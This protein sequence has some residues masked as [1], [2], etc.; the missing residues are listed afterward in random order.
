MGKLTH[1][2]ATGCTYF[3]TTDAWQKRATFQVVEIAEIVVQRIL[4]CRDQGAYLL[5]EFVLMPDHLHLLI[6]PGPTCALEKAMMLIKGGSSHQIHLV[7]GNKMGIWQSGF[8]DWTIRD[9][10]DYEA[11]S[12]Y[13]RINPV[14]TR[15]V[16]QPG[17]WAYGSASGKFLL[18]PIPERLKALAS[19]AKAPKKAGLNVG[20]EAPTP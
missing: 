18:D 11:R 7:R 5:H 17:E 13:I 4:T 2:T 10:A 16:E 9:L 8:H 20:A 15:L 3:V 14:V 6:T 19:G 1:R 12:T